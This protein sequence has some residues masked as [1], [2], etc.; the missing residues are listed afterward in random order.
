MSPNFYGT[1]LSCVAAFFTVLSIGIAQAAP[2]AQATANKSNIA[3]PTPPAAPPKPFFA[4]FDVSSAAQGAGPGSS[5]I[6]ITSIT[7]TNFSSSAQSVYVF[8][9]IYGSDTTSCTAAV[10]GGTE[11][12]IEIEVQAKATISVPFPSGLVFHG[13]TPNCVAVQGQTTGVDAYLVGYTQ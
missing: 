3:N 5:K 10:A 7:L 6:V 12:G 9:P 8:A 2:F 11:P 4:A 13:F 1:R